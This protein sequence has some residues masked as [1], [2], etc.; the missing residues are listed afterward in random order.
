MHI[1]HN[2]NLKEE[3]ERQIFKTL[4]KIFVRLVEAEVALFFPSQI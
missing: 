1:Y 4:E 3:E 2:L